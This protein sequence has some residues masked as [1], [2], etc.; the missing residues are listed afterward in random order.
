[1]TDSSFTLV[2]RHAC[3]GGEVR[4]LSHQSHELGLPARL[5]L[6]LPEK[7]LA[8]EHVPAVYVLAGLT[9]TQ[10]TFLIKSNAI[11]YA[12]EHGLALVAPDTSPRGADVAGEDETYDLGTG[13]GYY[14]DATSDPW[15][16]H[17]RM[18]SYVRHELP[19][20]MEKH[21]PIKA[22][23]RGIM[24]HSMGGMGALSVALGDA[25]AWTTVSAF[26]PIASPSQ[27]DW[28]QKAT[29]AYFGGHEA[30]WGQ[31]DPCLLLKSGRTHPGTFLIDQGLDDEFLDRLRPDLLEQTARDAGQS[32]LLRRHKGY[33]HSYWFVQ[34]FI[35]DHL[36]HH[37]EGLL[38]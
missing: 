2:E 15:A 21:F 6:F 36:K 29:A 31:Y 23:R 10:D 30:E 13:A 19:V 34:S 32:V 38:P 33:D 5:N 17:Y 7:A 11:R 25:G 3:C 16:A 37:A 12:A 20:L 14:V 8:G 1:M 9:C 35:Q 4:F 22:G 27:V 28:G 24:G 18:G 26:A